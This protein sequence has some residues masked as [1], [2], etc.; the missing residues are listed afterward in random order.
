M[1][2]R[3]LFFNHLREQW[4]QKHCKKKGKILSGIKQPECLG[5]Y[6]CLLVTNIMWQQPLNKYRIDAV[7]ETHQQHKQGKWHTF[8]ED[9]QE[10]WQVPFQFQLARFLQYSE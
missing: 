3:L 6:S 5:I 7:V 8:F 2:Y 10:K 1:N 4:Q 9:H